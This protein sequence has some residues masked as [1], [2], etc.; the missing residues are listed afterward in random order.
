V[1]P[2]ILVAFDGSESSEVAI[3][4]VAATDWPSGT[5]IFVLGVH[6][7]SLPFHRSA[8][9]ELRQDDADEAAISRAARE[10][11]REA[12]ADAAS[13]IA[14]TGLEVGWNLVDGDP[15]AVLIREVGDLE[16]DLAVTGA[17]APEVIRDEVRTSFTSSVLEAAPCPVLAVRRPE[18][19]PAALVVESYG[20]SSPAAAALVAL[21][22]PALEDIRVFG[23][24]TAD[25]PITTEL[26]AGAV[27]EAQRE[28]ALAEREAA[29]R[30]G[31]HLDGVLEA[32]GSAG[33]RPPVE[34]AMGDTVA[35]ARDW[36][37]S[38][39]VPTLVAG[40]AR[41]LVAEPPLAVDWQ[42]GNE[43]AGDLLRGVDTNLLAIPVDRGPEIQHRDEHHDDAASDRTGRAR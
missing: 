21:G 15:L 36:A 6:D 27:D 11:G 3:Q 7:E 8:S 5:R 43:L 42:R 25:V 9:R 1:G 22:V 28:Q 33:I 13:R 37:A 10:M 39:G 29:A 35:I 38:Q 14:A 30:L 12:L 34:T 17:R 4:L 16:V 32:L 41:R 19:R 23:V 18:L 40:M 26:A 24:A 31:S 2:R 20:L